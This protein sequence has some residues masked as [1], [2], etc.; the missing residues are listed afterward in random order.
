M[1]RLEVL[2][3]Y[4]TMLKESRK[5]P[6]YNFREY[7]LR[8]VRDAFKEN[9]SISN[10]QIGVLIEKA[11]KNLETIKRQAIIGQLYATD[12]LVIEHELQK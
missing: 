5:I 2:K 8:R 10:N 4:K 12:K 11:E 7:A 3:L 6:S 9:K 1:S